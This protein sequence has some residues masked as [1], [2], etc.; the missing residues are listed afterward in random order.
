MW[1]ENH[2]CLKIYPQ[3]PKKMC[4]VSIRKRVKQEGYLIS[5][6]PS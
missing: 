1:C 4:V 3:K 5:G 2:N 6:C